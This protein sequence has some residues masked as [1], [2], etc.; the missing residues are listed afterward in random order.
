[1]A[2]VEPAVQ[3]GCDGFRVESS[4]GLLG[5]VEE[6]WLA[7]DDEPDALALRL[8]DGRRALILAADVETVVAER[9]Q[10]A[11]RESARVLELGIPHVERFAADGGPPRLRASWQTTG[12]LLEPPQPPG[13]LRHA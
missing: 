4:R 5:W 7:Q 12:E 10:I 6:T 8:V 3:V 9:E 2:A 1:M 11:V 13:K